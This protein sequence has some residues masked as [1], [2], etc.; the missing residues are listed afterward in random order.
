MPR[1]TP[2]ANP[3][4][5]PTIDQHDSLIRAYPQLENN[6]HSSYQS[7]FGEHAGTLMLDGTIVFIL[8]FIFF[9]GIWISL[10]KKDSI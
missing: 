5:A 8:G 9:V 6:F 10:K 2:A 7:N 1:I 4:D 3:G